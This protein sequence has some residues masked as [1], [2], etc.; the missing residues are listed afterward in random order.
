[1]KALY[2]EFKKIQNK[3]LLILLFL[4]PILVSVILYTYR[5]NLSVDFRAQEQQIAN[6]LLSD[7]N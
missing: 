2:F 1:M 6:K 5:A 7:L 4:V 3:Q